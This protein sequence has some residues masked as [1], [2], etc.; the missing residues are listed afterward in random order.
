M[1]ISLYTVTRL[2]MA[3]VAQRRFGPEMR[4]AVPPGSRS[5]GC[6]PRRTEVTVEL[7]GIATAKLRAVL[8]DP[9]GQHDLPGRGRRRVG[10]PVGHREVLVAG[11]QRV[12]EHRVQPPR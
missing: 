6:G 11:E 9:V 8:R 3:G 5:C 4:Q 7:V 2:L 10:Q 12:P 1:Y